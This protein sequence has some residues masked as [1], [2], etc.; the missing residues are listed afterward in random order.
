MF[1]QIMAKMEAGKRPA[2]IIEEDSHC[3]SGIE[4][5]QLHSDQSIVIMATTADTKNSNHRYCRHSHLECPKFEGDDF[6]GWLMK[7]D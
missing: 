4:S 2:E 1:E 3:K 6:D 7:L 5:S